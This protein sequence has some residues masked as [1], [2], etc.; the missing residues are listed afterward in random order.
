MPGEGPAELF[1]KLRDERARL[2]GMV[3]G[4][5]EE[6]LDRALAPGEWT[7]RQQLAHL[8]E[9]EG[10]W[11]AWAL[12]I[13]RSSRCQ[14]G[15]RGQTPTP[16][17]ERGAEQSREELLGAL[18]EARR[19]T[20]A[21]AARLGPRELARRGQ[22]RWFGPLSTLQCLR[23]IYRHD[24]MHVEQILGQ[25]T[26]VRLPEAVDPGDS[27]GW[28]RWTRRVGWSDVDASMAWTFTAVQRYAEEAEVELLREA[29]VLDLL[30]PRLPRVHVEASYLAPV[31][32]DEEVDV[33]LAVA[34]LGRSSIGYRFRV[35]RGPTLCAE[36]RMTGACVGE[37]GRALE[38][39]EEARSALEARLRAEGGGT[40]R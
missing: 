26:S 39:P 20:I 37:D 6:E 32:F 9:M 10:I 21:A 35:L 30:Y 38:L 28:F 2:L 11:L 34:R 12:S 25:P 7:V 33:E 19:R 36:G 29:D 22:H 14:V 23:A 31:H 17:V 24:R 27:E 3:E 5:S 18:G 13:A 1:E 40:W 15:D 8:A 4:S 16:S